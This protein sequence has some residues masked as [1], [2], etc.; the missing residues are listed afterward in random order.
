MASL[1]DYYNKG[2]GRRAPTGYSFRTSNSGKDVYTPV[3][4]LNR[5][6]IIEEIQ[7]VWVEDVLI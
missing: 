2:S 6:I 5:A 4:D 7:V 1:F 3:N